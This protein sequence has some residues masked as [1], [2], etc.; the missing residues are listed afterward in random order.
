MPPRSS[1]TISVSHLD[2]AMDRLVWRLYMGRIARS[3]PITDKTAIKG[4][5]NHQIRARYE[6]GEGLS[7]LARIY[8]ISKQRVWQLVRSRISR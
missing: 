5:R 3:M 1:D 4:R 6:A 2:E 8:G 7:E